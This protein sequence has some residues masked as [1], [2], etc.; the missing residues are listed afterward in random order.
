[1]TVKTIGFPGR[2]L[3]GPG[4]I[5]ELGSLLKELDSRFPVVVADDVVRHAA[6]KVMDE[7][8][9][10]A[11]IIAR[12]LR[13]SGECTAGEIGK[14]VEAAGSSH[15][16][17][18]IG[19]GGGKTIDTAKGV[20]KALGCRLIIVPSIAS[21]DSPTSRLIVLYDDQHGVAGVE[22][23]ARNPDVVLV[24]TAIIARAP[25]RFFI[26]GLGD[27]LSKKFEAAQCHLA[28]G[29]N[30]FG[31]ESLATARL[32][33]D[34]CYETIL[35]FGLDAVAQVRAHSAPNDAVERCIEASVLLSG[36]GFE[37]GGLSLSHALTRG[38]TAHPELSK[39]LHGELV[40]F[41]TIVQ[42][43]A[44]NRPVA[45]IQKHTK[46]CQALGLPVSFA[47][48]NVQNISDAALIDIAEKTHA[49]PYIGNL[50]PA[51]DVDRIVDCLQRADLLGNSLVQRQD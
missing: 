8:L 50:H 43:I 11:G 41:G 47:E 36:L 32:L 48:M 16:D 45:E 2:Y 34:H 31:T 3:Q 21:N 29:K 42:L 6:G 13:F 7:A 38:F 20:A 37:S 18:V 35:E 33:A 51:A 25:V 10:T 5:Q 40:G 49:A 26:A 1:M 46:F 23:M 22:K 17:M 9:A 44:E 30:F 27:A 4:A 28:G 12:Q 19:F 15:V 24:D 39:F 14:L